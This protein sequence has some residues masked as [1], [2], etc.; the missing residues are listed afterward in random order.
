MVEYL[1]F[2]D[3]VLILCL[4][5]SFFVGGLL[6]SFFLKL[7]TV[8]CYVENKSL[9]VIWTI[10]PSIILI[11]IAFPSLKLL[12]FLDFNK[13]NSWNSKFDRTIN[14]KILSW[15][16]IGHQ[17]Y[18]RYECKILNM[19]YDSFMIKNL[20]LKKGWARGLEVDLPF[21]G[22]YKW[23]SDLFISSSD[24]IHSF[25]L[26]TFGIKC[27]AVPGRINN[28]SLVNRIYGVFYGQCSEICG[29]NH[30]FMP[31]CLEI[32]KY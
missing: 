6:F 32:I 23:I 21:L 24:V 1:I 9:E 13:F 20:D 7:S 25:S 15:K 14:K 18:W 2:N 12:Y 27:D 31:I 28:V 19:C 26:P 5:I 3:K 4:I 10:I 17:W 16:I 29:A 11:F 22:F 8:I 30:S